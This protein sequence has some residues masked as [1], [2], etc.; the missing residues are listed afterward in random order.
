MRD[1][2]KP[3]GSTVALSWRPN[4]DEPWVLIATLYLTQ[5][6]LTRPQGEWKIE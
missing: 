6:T 3:Y 5:T 1:V 4:P 2:V